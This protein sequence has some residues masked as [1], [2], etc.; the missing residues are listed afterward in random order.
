[1]G[2]GTCN[3]GLG[4]LN[5]SSAFGKTDYKDLLRRWLD[6]TPE[7]WGFRSQN[8]ISPVRGAAL[9][10]GFNRQPHYGRGLLLVG[11]AGGMINPFNGE[12][13]AYAME[14]A[15][16]AAESIAEAHYRG[17]GTASAERALA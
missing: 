10:M 2:D 16:I 7:D 4:I 15:E 11:D 9:P 13:I 6:N 12:G 5:T 3:V 17:A 14:S 8:M 1:M